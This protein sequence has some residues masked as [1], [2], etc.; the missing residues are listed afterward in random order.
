MWL[1]A[2]VVRPG[3]RR[4]VLVVCNDGAVRVVEYCGFGDWY[5]AS[6]PHDPVDPVHWRELPPLPDGD[7]VV[8]IVRVFIQG[9][10][11]W[12]GTPTIDVVAGPPLEVPPDLP[13][14]DLLAHLLSHGWEVYTSEAV[15]SGTQHWLRRTAP[16]EE[17]ARTCEKR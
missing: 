13:P 7:Q 4:P 3:D 15:G 11:A 12:A 6:P 1:R 16:P 17:S 14:C 10:S 2:S 9:A 5:S 8:S